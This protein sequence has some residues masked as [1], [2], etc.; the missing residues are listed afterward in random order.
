[1]IAAVDGYW[2]VSSPVAVVLSAATFIA[3]KQ[4]IVKSASQKVGETPA[5]GL[6]GFIG[7]RVRVR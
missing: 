3:P 4:T 1:M 5:V 6:A 7:L 2:N